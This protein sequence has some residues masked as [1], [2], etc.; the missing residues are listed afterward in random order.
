M[1]F[2]LVAL[3]T[4]DPNMPAADEFDGI[5]GAIEPENP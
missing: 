2:G 5:D 3:L 1:P 4:M